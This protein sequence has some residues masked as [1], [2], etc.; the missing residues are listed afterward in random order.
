MADTNTT[1]PEVKAAPKAKAPEL[2]AEMKEL[3]ELRNFKATTETKKLRDAG[4]TEEYENY[5]VPAKE[6]AMILLLVRLRSTK[7]GVTH[8]TER[9]AFNK[10]AYNRTILPNW[11]SLG[12][13]VVKVLNLPKGELTPAQY[14]EKIAKAAAEKAAKA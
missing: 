6:K 8:K 1:P 13:E 5:K 3:Q 2:S 10:Q 14:A 11:N 7:V 12:Y 9:Q 4:I